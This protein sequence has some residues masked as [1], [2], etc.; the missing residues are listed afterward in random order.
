MST[1]PVETIP[2]KVDSQGVARIGDSRVTLDVLAAEWNSGATPEQIVEQFPS[3]A[4]ADIYAVVA[5]MLRHPNELSDYL[6]AGTAATDEV[7]KRIQA[8]GQR[9][10]LRA[11]LLARRSN[12]ARE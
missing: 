2:I 7:V 4:L 8:A 12:S 3:L 5:W 10:G 9:L 11:L 6:A 1:E